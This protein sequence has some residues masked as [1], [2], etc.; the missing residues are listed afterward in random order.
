MLSK[1]VPQTFD[2]TAIIAVIAGRGHYPVQT[3]ERIRQAQVPVK[4][5]AFEDETLPELW[6]SFNKTDR[7]ML[8]VGQLGKLLKSLKKMDARY[9]IM[10]GQIRPK[11]LFKGLHPDLKAV[12]ILASLKQKNAETIFSAIASEIEKIG[13]TQ[14]DARAFLDDQLAHPGT[15]G[16]H[17]P[18]A[19]QESID[20]GVHIAKEMARLDV[21]QGVV[22]R[23]GT[24][25][26]VEAF[27]G[28]DPML[29]RAGSFKT[30]S[31]VFAKT[32]KPNQDYRFDVPV[33]GMRTIEV[34]AKH[35]IHTA[36]LE[37]ENTLIL[38]KEKVIKQA[39]ELGICLMG[40]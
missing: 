15:M 2:P 28:T 13:V 14:L 23:K 11:R 36:A 17:K 4:L 3:V 6:E 33:F 12:R 35:N 25:I 26:A 19:S 10:A 1:F 40:Y 30:D 9:T 27:E 37:A 31:L 29:E 34:M 8:K 24:V 32:A 20:Y 5:I 18:K 7:I 22:V 16:K 39:N 38:D 21:G